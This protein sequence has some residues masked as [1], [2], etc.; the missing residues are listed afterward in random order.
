MSAHLWHTVTAFAGALLVSASVAMAQA[1]STANAQP[2]GRTVTKESAGTVSPGAAAAKKS[3]MPTEVTI[4]REVFDYNGG[5][6]RDPYKSLMSTSD[7]R[8]LLS[9]LQLSV[10]VLDKDGNNSIAFLKDDFSKTK[11]RV[12]VG[13]QVGRLRVSAIKQKEVQFTVEEFGF[14]RI[15]TLTRS[16]DTTKVRNP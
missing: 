2:V 4:Q 3:V 13:Q 11:Y 14:N 8:P 16:S 10:V 1:S 5:G 12:K 15:E 9:D 7:V 6:R